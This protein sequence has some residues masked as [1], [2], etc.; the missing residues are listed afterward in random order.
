M[1]EMAKIIT[2]GDCDKPATWLRCTQFA[3][4]HPFCSKHAK[5]QNDFKLR[6]DGH[7][8]AWCRVKKEKR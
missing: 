7:T 8:Y 2:C 5:A 6:T 4:E 1:F 3:G